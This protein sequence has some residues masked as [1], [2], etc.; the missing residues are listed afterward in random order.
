MQAF[1][2]DV[3]S[4]LEHRP[5]AVRADSILYRLRKFSRRNALAVAAAAVLAFVML[6]S[7]VGLALAARRTAHEAQA[8]LAVKNFLF[9][10]FSAV[11][12]TEA[13]GRAISVRELLDR[14]RDRLQTE[15]QDDPA[16]KAELQAVLGR[17]YSQLGLY[18]QARDLQQQAVSALK[19]ESIHR[20]VARKPG[21]TSPI[22]CANSASSM[23]RA[24]PWMMLTCSCRAV[25]K[26]RCPIAPAC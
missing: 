8:T 23:P 19:Q 9:S 4:H 1:A 13:K 25:P 11:D 12:P 3:R 6:G 17:I 22:R 18:A 7:A 5:I 2:D 16:L 20:C 21:S 24:P 14:G 10:L 26:R 15:T